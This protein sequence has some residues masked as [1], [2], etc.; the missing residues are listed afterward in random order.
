MDLQDQA[1]KPT[2]DVDELPGEQG[3]N[4]DGHDQLL[5][6]GRLVFS[7]GHADLTT[8]LDQYSAF[9][10]V[11]DLHSLTLAK[12]ASNDDACSMRGACCVALYGL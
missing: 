7:D 2:I 1:R 12:W 10:C 5:A 11:E 9:I 3:G 4:A 8:W 6:H